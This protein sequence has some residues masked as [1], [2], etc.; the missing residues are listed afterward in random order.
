M[1]NADAPASNMALPLSLEC[2]VDP[3]A[4]G[5]PPRGSAARVLVVDAEPETWRAVRAGMRHVGFTAEWASTGAKGLALVGR[6]HPDV[7]ILELALPDVDGLEV[8]RHLRKWSQVPIL[9]LS[10][11]TGEGDKVSALKLGADDYLTK[12]FSMAELIVR[13]QVA[14]RHVAQATG[15]YHRQASFQT[16]G[17]LIDFEQRQVTV[18]GREVHVTPTEYELLKYLASNAG[19]VLTHRAILSAG[20]GQDHEHEVYSLRVFFSQLRRKVE[21]DPTRPRYLQTERGIGYR[22]RSDGSPA[23]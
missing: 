13:V 8:C 20:W 19:K 12:P 9:V 4:L 3:H 17:L 6:W 1:N 18:E 15:G 10:G 21:P 22:L 2:L 16:G 14:L 23:Q 5:V 11:R 7:I